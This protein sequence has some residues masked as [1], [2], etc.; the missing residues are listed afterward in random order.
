MLRASSS[1]FA[2]SNK[3]IIAGMP[4]KRDKIISTEPERR[5]NTLDVITTSEK[6]PRYVDGVVFS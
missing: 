6:H 3:A 2:G 1:C 4:W 5:K